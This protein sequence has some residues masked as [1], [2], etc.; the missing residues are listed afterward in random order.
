MDFF[1]KKN[2]YGTKNI[3]DLSGGENF[4]S[5]GLMRTT[6]TECMSKH[7]VINLLVLVC[8]SFQDLERLEMD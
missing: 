3:I 7:I 8:V 2:I 6:F 5:K 4:Q 1:D